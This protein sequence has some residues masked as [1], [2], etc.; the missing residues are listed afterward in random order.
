MSGRRQRPEPTIR[1]SILLPVL[2]VVDGL[3]GETEALLTRQRLRR[4][5]LQDPY[6]TVPLRRY[7]A[8][9]EEAA[10]H[11][12]NPALGLRIGALLRPADLGPAGL[13]FSLAP[14]L[15][16]GFAQLGRYLGTLQGGTAIALDERPGR[17]AFAYRME[18][19]SIWPR[20]QDSELT[21]AA[22]CGLVRSRLG[23]GWAPIEVH[24]DHHG[25]PRRPALRQ[26]FQAPVLFRQPVTQLL[27]APGELDLPRRARD[28]DVLPVLERH[29]QDLL[30]REAPVPDRPPDRLSDQV[31]RLIALRIARGEA[32][33]ETG[34]ALGVA[35]VAAGL[36][37]S[38]R[39]LQRGLAAEGTT[40]RDLLRAHRQ[41][42]AGARLQAGG[43]TMAQIARAL[44]YSDATVF[45][46]AFRTWN[47]TAPSAA[48]RRR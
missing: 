1:A 23:S 30:A 45:W 8:L 13:L 29:A 33:G 18:D 39:T 46:R 21:L 28:V 27:I 9:L 7:V 16:L 19:P 22:M 10:A 26:A 41:H 44:G 12:G 38:A 36:G 25:D 11:L 2:R 47:G 6:A 31:R 20:A 5:D 42:L 3:G 34:G 37:L 40:L 35:A 48:R 24:F 17:A 14:T 32:G 15:R 43:E 4:A